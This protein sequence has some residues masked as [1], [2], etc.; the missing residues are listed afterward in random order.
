MVPVMKSIVAL[1]AG[2]LV[3]SLA[4]ASNPPNTQ[5]AQVHTVYLLPMTN[6]LDQY[7]ANRLTNLG[8][9][10]VVS[11]PSKADAVLTDRLGDSFEK[12]LGELF[13]TPAP[14]EPPKKEPAAKKG[15]EAKSVEIAEPVTK[16]DTSLRFSSFRRAKGTVFLVG[17]WNRTVLW[18]VYDQAKDSSAV[19]MDRAASR[20]AS[21]LQRAV[22]VK[23]K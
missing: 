7:L 12:R 16:G 21:Q 14:A 17:A 8:V 9:F 2:S 4:A 10:Q 11:D 5:V 1:L 3:G 22:K 19:E 18:S 20:I 13:P 15:E 23:G 6:G